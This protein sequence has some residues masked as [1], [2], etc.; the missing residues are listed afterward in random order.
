MDDVFYV[1]WLFISVAHF[2]AGMY[3]DNVLL[4]LV[5]LCILI[6]LILL[7]MA[8]IRKEI[9]KMRELCSEVRG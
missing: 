2:I 6:F 5:G 1:V 7:E 8:E 3:R 9:R 4:C